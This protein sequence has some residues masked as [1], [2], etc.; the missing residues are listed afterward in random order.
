MRRSRWLAK[1]SRFPSEMETEISRY[2]SILEKWNRKIRLVSSAESEGDFMDRHARDALELT[3]FL[4]GV[5]TLIDVGTGAGLP[6]I[7]LKVLRPEIDVVLLDS[8][9]KKIGFCE[10]AIRQLGLSGI[11]AV[12]GRAEDEAVR[13][14]L[15][16]F[17]AVVSRATW[18]LDDYIMISDDYMKC[19]PGSM[20]IALK[21]AKWRDELDEAQN[22]LGNHGLILDQAHE[23]ALSDET[24]RCILIFKRK[25]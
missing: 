15:G 4:D 25:T 19:S 13:E 21:G 23:Y 18:R 17:D 3:P 6:G 11:R 12:C 9:R 10:E 2:F 20:L 7:L 1:D 24:P 22:A 8:I 16:R 5:G 14:G